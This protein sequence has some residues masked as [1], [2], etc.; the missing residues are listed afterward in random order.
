MI[1]EFGSGDDS[2]VVAHKVLE[3]VVLFAG[4]VEFSVMKCS[5]PEIWLY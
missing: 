1:E 2:V 4:E 3:K 5:E